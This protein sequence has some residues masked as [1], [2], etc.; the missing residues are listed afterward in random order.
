M[1][2]DSTIRTSISNENVRQDI[3]AQGDPTQRRTLQTLQEN[4]AGGDLNAAQSQY[5][6]LRDLFRAS[7]TVNGA[8]LV[9]STQLSTRPSTLSSALSSGN[10]TTFQAAFSTFLKGLNVFG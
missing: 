8:S 2:I 9:S 3:L 7:A 6:G 10:L 1:T 5:Q 4:I